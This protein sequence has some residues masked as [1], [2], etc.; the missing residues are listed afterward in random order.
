MVGYVLLVPHSG[1]LAAYFLRWQQVVQCFLVPQSKKNYISSSGSWVSDGGG[2]GGD[3]C[4]ND[5]EEEH[6]QD[7]HCVS[8]EKPVSTVKCSTQVYVLLEQITECNFL[9]LK[10]GYFFLFFV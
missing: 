7:H 2:G 9:F 3:E 1:E 4:D 5:E 10:C 6:D 8:T